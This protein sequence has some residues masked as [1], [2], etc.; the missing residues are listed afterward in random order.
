MGQ[1]RRIIGWCLLPR[2]A[3]RKLKTGQTRSALVFRRLGIWSVTVVAL[4][5]PPAGLGQDSEVP[6]FQESI[7]VH[8]VK[9]SVRVDNG[10]GLPVDGLTVEDFV[11]TEDGASVEMV[12][13]RLVQDGDPFV[14]L[15][16]RSGVTPGQIAL[17]LSEPAATVQSEPE[18][19]VILTDF[20]TIRPRFV[21]AMGKLLAW[22]SDHPQEVGERTWMVGFVDRTVGFLGGP[23]S[24]PVELKAK[25][26]DLQRRKIQG[27][28]WRFIESPANAS[29]VQ[30]AKG[31][32]A[33]GGD[34]DLRQRMLKRQGCSGKLGWIMSQIDSL[35]RL[36]ESLAPIPGRK[37]VVWMHSS[38]Y[39]KQEEGCSKGDVFKA[40]RSLSDLGA[41]ATSAGVIFHA[42]SL[43]G[44]ELFS[45][46]EVT[47][48][49]MNSVSPRQFESTFS[50]GTMAKS[51][52]NHT[53]GQ[54]VGLNDPSWIFHRAFKDTV[55]EIAVL[56]PH[57]RDGKEHDIKVKIKQGY[58]LAILRYPLTYLDLSKKQL[59][60]NQLQRLSM[61]PGSY[62]SFPVYLRTE[63]GEMGETVSVT[64]TI[65]VPAGQIGMVEEDG[66]QIARLEPY[67]SVHNLEGELVEFLQLNS[68]EFHIQA[69]VDV[70]PEARLQA[71]AQVELPPGEYLINGAFYD[72]LN[73]TA[74]VT[75][76]RLALLG[77]EG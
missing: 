25:L 54:K 51:L 37:S 35:G 12:D 14:P 50:L 67:I 64:V 68:S 19:V 66:E 72:S 42:S 58:P 48:S 71:T 15:A 43:A 74:G 52:A 59:L 16:E 34:E 77:D 29:W 39:F 17:A 22:V 44:L 32:Q 9:L 11:V 57:G 4:A 21:A 60:M 6:V 31:G 36:V 41:I 5:G 3:V 47:E 62:G 33:S 75:S 20:Q 55:Y 65:A 2:L 45:N 53:G 40:V 10:L 8:E 27:R 18:L 23:T 28:I 76:T 7:E 69:G 38:V 56:V 70:G 26:R 1:L 63:T 30:D 61:L 13:F 73:D 24:D 46:D 49:N